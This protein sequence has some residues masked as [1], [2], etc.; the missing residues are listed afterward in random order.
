MPDHSRQPGEGVWASFAPAKGTLPLEVASR[1]DKRFLGRTEIAVF[2]TRYD[3]SLFDESTVELRHTGS[4][5]RSGLTA[6][7]KTGGEA[8]SRL[9]EALSTDRALTEAVLPLDFTRFEVG[10]DQTGCHAR[11]ELMGASHVAMALPPIRSYVHLHADQREALLAAFVEVGR[12]LR[13]F[14]SVDS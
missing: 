9:A 6:R 3:V 2:R 13:R 5:R 4:T 12:V 8:A 7:T 11:V 14:R 1:I 10:G